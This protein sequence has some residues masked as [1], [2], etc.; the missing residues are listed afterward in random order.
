[1]LVV[2]IFYVSVRLVLDATYA[3]ADPRVRG[4]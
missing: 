2:G 1:V 4:A 3:W